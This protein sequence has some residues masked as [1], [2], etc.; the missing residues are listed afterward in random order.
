VGREM[1]PRSMVGLI[2]VE[3]ELFELPQ[4]V[5][6]PLNYMIRGRAEIWISRSV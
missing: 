4:K 3:E 1:Y 2:H 6:L 5:C